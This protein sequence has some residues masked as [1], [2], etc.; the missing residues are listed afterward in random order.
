V[1]TSPYADSARGYFAAG[2]APLPIRG[3][4]PPPTGYTGND[5]AWPSMADVLSWEDDLG[6][7]NVGLRL[8]AHVIGIDV[9][10][11]GGKSGAA[12]LSAAEQKWGA[13]PPTWVTT[14]RIDGSGI[15][16]FSIPEGMQWPG[17][18]PGGGVEII[19]AGHRYAMC[20]PSVHP[21]TGATYEWYAPDRE[22]E[23]ETEFEGGLPHPDALPALPQAWVDG[24]TGGRQ[25]ADL[26]RADLADDEAS[27][28]LATHG[29]GLPCP[30]MLRA[31]GRSASDMAAGG[32]R[33]EAA[34]RGTCRVAHLVQ[35]GH[36]GGAEAIGMI[37]AAFGEATGH[38]AARRDEFDRM[39]IGAVRLAVAVG[40]VST[41]GDPCASIWHG[42]QPAPRALPTPG[43]A[44]ST[45]AAPVSTL[46]TVTPIVAE[47]AVTDP[48]LDLALAIELAQ[49]RVRRDA[50]RLLDDEEASASFVPPPYMPTLTAEL[51]LPD[52]EI[53]YR[54]A[55][56]LPAGGN[57]LLAAQFK[58]GKTTLITN[59]ARSL[60]DGVPFLGQL[61]VT[62]LAPGQ[63]VAIWNYEVSRG[64]YRRWLRDAGIENADAVVIL[65]L[66]GFRLPFTSR[67]IEEW[68]VE[69]LVR[70]HVG[71]WFVDPF[72]RAFTGN[73]ENDNTEVARW[74]DAL[75]AIKYRAEVG[76]LVLPTH[77]G[78]AIAE[79]GQ[80]RA[81]G[82]TRLDDW[83]DV[84]WMLN[85]DSEGSR[86]FMATGRD[87]DYPEKRLG[88]NEPSRRL[89]IEGGDRAAT[90]FERIENGVMAAVHARPGMGSAELRE[91]ASEI[92][93]GGAKAK[94]VDEAVKKLVAAGH[95]KIAHEPHGKLAHYPDKPPIWNGK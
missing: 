56:V 67:R 21:E 15:R 63:R 33:H 42:G 59:L 51:A 93:A 65:N 35:E 14:S 8:P 77:T 49:Q 36:I 31:V 95:I 92:I 72:A 22:T 60:A 1:S 37:R 68:A 39:I 28:W 4:W 7:Y 47:V 2:W 16:L 17:E 3:K 32:S 38:Q 9:D 94:S 25:A 24:L 66:R 29:L 34:S 45:P 88:Y 5:G 20:W 89:V 43:A 87:V 79:E 82:A 18:L 80:E 81:R 52:D 61:A 12:T 44:V 46:A 62:R 55:E 6:H 26:A 10:T 85:K 74:L 90:R 50:K 23:F 11:Y 57:V 64:Q 91:A 19:R 41:S 70:H 76:E 73:N 69:W 71:V 40:D 27:M 75:D 30:A 58:A 86:F 84:R 54:V 83:A 53:E 48:A 13:L 78:R